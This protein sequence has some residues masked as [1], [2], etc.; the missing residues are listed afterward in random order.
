MLRRKTAALLLLTLL[1]PVC[2]AALAAFAENRLGLAMF[3]GSGFPVLILNLMTELFLPIILFMQAADSFAGE[4]GDRTLKISLLRP[5]SRF[6]LYASKQLALF[7]WIMILLAGAAV[8][9][10]ATAWLL[11]LGEASAKAVADT[12][13]AYTAAVLPM[14]ALSAAAAMLSQWFKSGS[15]ALVVALFLYAAAK[16]ASLFFGDAAYFSPTAYTDWHLLWLGESVGWGKIGS[17]FLFLAG[18]SIVSFTAGFYWFDRK[19]L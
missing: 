9:S 11:G 12:A 2:G 8:C 3:G 6:S 10:V 17:I 16:I 5:I 7:I 19:E 13:L 18:C 4:A 1:L 14:A 15:G